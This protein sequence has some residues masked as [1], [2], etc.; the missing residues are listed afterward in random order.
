[1]RFAIVPNN[2]HFA[3]SM[4]A[5]GRRSHSSREGAAGLHIQRRGREFM[6]ILALNRNGVG[7]SDGDIQ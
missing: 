2:E 3:R 7:L 5:Q 1:M 4:N 6:P